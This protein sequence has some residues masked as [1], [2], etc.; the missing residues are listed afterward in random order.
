MKACYRFRRGCGI[1]TQ[2]QAPGHVHGRCSKINFERCTYVNISFA[3]RSYNTG[4]SGSFYDGVMGSLV[5]IVIEQT[6]RGE[7]S[8]DIFSRMLKERIIFLHGPV[9]DAMAI[10]T[11]AQLLFLESENP[12]KPINLY[13]N[14]PGGSVT[15]GMAI[16][17]TMQ[18]VGCPIHTLCMGQASSMGSLLLTAGQHGQRRSLPNARMMLHQ[19]SGGVQ[20]MASDIQIQAEEILKLKKNLTNIYV[21]H[22]G[23]DI[24]KVK[25]VLDRDFFFSAEEAVEFGL[26]DEVIVER[27]SSKKI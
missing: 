21:K 8:F 1:F 12:G 5:P 22:T 4:S 27:T 17:D 24:K 16:Y 14:S 11:T 13:I 18:Y 6:P 10:S 3:L 15:A 20:G 26:I 23:Q 25:D 2:L 7:R 19:P 9:T